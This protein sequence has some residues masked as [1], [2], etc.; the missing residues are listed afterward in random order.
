MPNKIIK[1]EEISN[2][3]VSRESELSSGPQTP[4][5]SLSENTMLK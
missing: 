3:A 1:Q 5:L 2:Y 4:E